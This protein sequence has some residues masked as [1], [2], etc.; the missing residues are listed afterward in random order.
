LPRTLDGR[1]IVKLFQQTL[2]QL[3]S[4]VDERR[5]RVDVDFVVQYVAVKRNL[6]QK[7][8]EQLLVPDFMPLVFAWIAAKVVSI[9]SARSTHVIVVGVD[10]IGFSFL[11]SC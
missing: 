1:L 6:V 4:K 11:S 10:R 9:W 5:L 2:H 7:K 3:H 8:S